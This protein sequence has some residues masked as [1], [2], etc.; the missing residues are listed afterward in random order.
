MST[1]LHAKSNQQRQHETKGVFNLLVVKGSQPLM[2]N[3][4]WW[5]SYADHLIQSSA[6][7]PLDHSQFILECCEDAKYLSLS[8]TSA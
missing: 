6:G 3:V 1:G 7:I 2:V 8:Y 4:G 5:Y